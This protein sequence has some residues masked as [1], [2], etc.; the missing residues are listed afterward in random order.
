MCDNRYHSKCQVVSKAL[1]VAS[2][3]AVSEEKEQ[4]G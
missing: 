2:Q 4:S 1:Y 3:E